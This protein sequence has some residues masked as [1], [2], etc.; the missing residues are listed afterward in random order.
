MM[1][2]SMRA[3]LNTGQYIVYKCANF[4]DVVFFCYKHLMKR[5][6]ELHLSWESLWLQG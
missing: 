4:Y 6:G 5:T 1:K 2:S 3:L